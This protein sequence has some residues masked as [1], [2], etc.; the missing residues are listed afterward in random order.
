MSGGPGSP[1]PFLDKIE[2]LFGF[3]HEQGFAFT[4][5]PF[6]IA[7]LVAVLTFLIISP[8]QTLRNFEFLVFT[9]P[10]WLSAVLVRFAIY[11]FV[12]ANRMQFLA[13]QEYVLLEIKLPRD[14]KKSPLAMETVLTN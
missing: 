9:S 13:R 11:R 6:I 7:G 2:K 10:I 5:R 12:E 14:I 8:A 3:G 4:A 1:L